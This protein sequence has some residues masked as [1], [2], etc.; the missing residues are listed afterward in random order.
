MYNLIK[1]IL[2]FYFKAQA[3]CFQNSSAKGT[4]VLRVTNTRL[5]S[6]NRGK[7]KVIMVK[8]WHHLSFVSS[9]DLSLIQSLPLCGQCQSSQGVKLM[10]ARASVGT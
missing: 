3:H 9:L 4:L 7:E 1:N 5:S 2:E 10:S 8:S 6:E